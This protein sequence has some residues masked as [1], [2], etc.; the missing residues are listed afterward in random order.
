MEWGDMDSIALAQDRDRWRALVNPIM[1][2]QLNQPT[3]CSNYSSLF[4]VV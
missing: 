4:L 2:F 1:H 3:R